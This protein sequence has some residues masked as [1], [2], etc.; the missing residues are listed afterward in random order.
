MKTLT[1]K[2]EIDF[3]AEEHADKGG[4]RNAFSFACGAEWADE[5]TIE[6]AAEWIKMNV[7]GWDDE[8]I[9][10]FEKAMKN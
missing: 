7:A 1:R 9:E 3:A 10:T 2:Q 8:F 4:G 6:K 5:T